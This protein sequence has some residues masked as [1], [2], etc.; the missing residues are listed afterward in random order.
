MSEERLFITP[1]QAESVLPDGDYI[2]NFKQ[3]GMMLLGCD[4]DRPNAV[5]ALRIAA[6][7]EIG[8]GACRGMGHGLVVWNT[9]TD[10][11][12]FAADNDALAALEAALSEQDA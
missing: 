1:E 6:Q 2:H 9:K 3:S 10:Y 8:G 12:F 4:Y 11:S 5:E 7:I